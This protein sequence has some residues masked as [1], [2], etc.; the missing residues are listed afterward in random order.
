MNYD[1][2]IKDTLAQNKLIQ[3]NEKIYLTKNQIE[4]LTRYQI[5]FEQCSSIKEI[6]FL[7]EEILESGDFDED[8]E[9]VSSSLQ[10]FDY[11]VNY[12]K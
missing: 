9:V 2:L 10:E 1:N 5:P 6:I 7:I 12:K 4:I 11:Y 3:V 8:L